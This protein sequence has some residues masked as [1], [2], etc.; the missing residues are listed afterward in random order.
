MAVAF[1][2]FILWIIY[3]ANTGGQSIF[4]DL[5]RW[6]P[7]GDKIGHFCLFGLLTLLANFALNLKTISLVK[8][9]VYLGALLV[10][11]FAITEELS[12]FFIVSRSLDI[13]DLFADIAGIGAF[14]AFTYYL[15]LRS[16]KNESTKQH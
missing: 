9:R 8:F 11:S 12:Q 10:F 2:C 4:F 16:L 7:Y 14:C 3:L 13:T 1:T 15:H 6:L 5:V